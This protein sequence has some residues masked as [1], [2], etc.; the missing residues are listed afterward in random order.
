[1]ENEEAKRKASP[2]NFFSCI[3]ASLLIHIVFFVADDAQMVHACWWYY[4]SKFTEFFDTV[5]REN[6]FNYERRATTKSFR[7]AGLLRVT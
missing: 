2:A 4:F 3:I 5:S 7:F 6:D 1:M